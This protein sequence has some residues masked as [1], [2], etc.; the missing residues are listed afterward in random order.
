MLGRLVIKIKLLEMGEDSGAS[1]SEEFKYLN[2]FLLH[3]EE[4]N[5]FD[6]KKGDHKFKFEGE[7]ITINLSHD[8]YNDP[9]VI[10][11]RFGKRLEPRY[12]VY[13]EPKDT[14]EIRDK[15]IKRDK[16]N[17]KILQ[18]ENMKKGKGK[19]GSIRII[20]RLILH[21]REG[22]IFFKKKKYVEKIKNHRLVEQGGLI[23][24]PGKVNDEF[25]LLKQ[26]GRRTGVKKPILKM[27]NK[28][29]KTSHIVMK[30]FKIPLSDILLLLK[31]YPEK[32]NNYE[33]YRF[34]SMLLRALKEQMH[35]K[36]IVHCDIKPDNIMIDY[37]YDSQKDIITIK[38]VDIIDVN[39]SRKLN[40]P[41]NDPALSDKGGSH[42]Y[43]APEAF[44]VCDEDVIDATSDFY[45]MTLVINELFQ[46]ENTR[47]DLTWG[48]FFDRLQKFFSTSKKTNKE[49]FDEFENVGS[50]QASVFE[51]ETSQRATLKNLIT[52]MLNITKKDKDKRSK[53]PI[54][55]FENLRI[56][57]KCELY[58]LNLLN[59]ETKP[60]IDP[61][62]YKAN[63]LKGYVKAKN[64]REELNT[65]S[66]DMNGM[67]LHYKMMNVILDNLNKITSHEE[68]E[69]FIETIDI[70]IFNNLYKESIIKTENYEETKKEIK[71]FTETMI[72]QFDQNR[73]HMV[74][75]F[76][77]VRG[78]LFFLDILYEKT[79]SEAV[80]E[81]I[82]EFDGLYEDIN[83]M[84]DKMANMPVTVDDIN[85]INSKFEIKLNE[86]TSRIEAQ[87]EIIDKNTP[88]KD[89]APLVGENLFGKLMDFKPTDPFYYVIEEIKNCLGEMHSYKEQYASAIDFTK[90]AKIIR[91]ILKSL[92]S[93]KDDTELAQ[94]LVPETTD[95]YNIEV[96]IEKGNHKEQKL[97]HEQFE[98]SFS[99]EDQI[100][101]DSKEAET[102]LALNKAKQESVKNY[103]KQILLRDKVEAY[104]LVT[105][106]KS[107][108][109]ARSTNLTNQILNLVGHK[110]QSYKSI[111]I[112][113][114]DTID[115]LNSHSVSEKTL[116][117]L[118]ID[119]KE[120]IL[121][122]IQE[123]DRLEKWGRGHFA[124][125]LK[126]T[127]SNKIAALCELLT[128]L[129]DQKNKNEFTHDIIF[130]WERKHR[131]L[132][133]THRGLFGKGETSTRKFA[134]E[135]IKPTHKN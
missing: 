102:K 59:E 30:R 51:E 53:D 8:L 116:N 4:K 37:E 15:K 25:Q 133:D 29:L 77:K 48:A 135:M 119:R 14:V 26:T 100:E 81:I 58:K 101:H 71:T 7:D 43:G 31:S 40:L 82:Q 21:K 104:R 2:A 1:Q 33:Y 128:E 70:Q 42:G 114:K 17:K 62:I 122:T 78:N 121:K 39:L 75:M 54:Q 84:L 130:D 6:I 79:K 76:N 73:N 32:L 61:A 36:D 18:F 85:A 88:F 99:I 74:S 124:F 52:A 69:E 123:I 24:P 44:P 86:F 109:I 9:K 108:E 28:D 5:I 80:K 68:L 23:N 95:V 111:F 57:Y 12:Y 126:D 107:D 46:G 105:Q 27:E 63:V 38:K 92:A 20:K 19:F 89:I 96:E 47:K 98:A 87:T 93:A 16:K 113:R 49:N 83:Y 41:K 60:K 67:D 10:K 125:F 56:E 22:G 3:C 129:T 118:P 65:I 91:G 45:S 13:T 110:T 35:D 64:V 112:D 103:I 90:D 50:R 120:A 55:E 66:D 97:E 132:I 34:A 94:R 127:S 106:K 72:K 115:L 131:F 134:N 117:T 11:G